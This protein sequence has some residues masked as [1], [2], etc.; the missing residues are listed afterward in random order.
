MLCGLLGMAAEEELA[1]V[2]R[3][4][5]ISKLLRPNNLLWLVRWRH[6]VWP[7]GHDSRRSAGGNGGCGN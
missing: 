5:V 4:P 2:A 3:E 6:A 1:A 7:A